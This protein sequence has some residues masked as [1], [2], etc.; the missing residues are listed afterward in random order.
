MSYH[1]FCHDCQLQPF[2]GILVVRCSKNHALKNSGSMPLDPL[3]YWCFYKAQSY[4]SPPS[5]SI[6]CLYPT[7]QYFLN[8]NL[9]M[10]FTKHALTAITHF[11]PCSSWS[12]HMLQL[13]KSCKSWSW[14]RYSLAFSTTIL[15]LCTWKLFTC[16]LLLTW[17][18]KDKHCLASPGLCQQPDLHR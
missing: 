10:N 14:C 5:F 15:T 3:R 11:K 7:L 6:L 1:E 16:H 8:E 4:Y 13:R 18:S 9:I 17:R 2:S 12:K